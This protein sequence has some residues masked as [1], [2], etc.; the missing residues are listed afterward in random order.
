[1]H[2]ISKKDIG[3]IDLFFIIL[4]VLSYAF[5]CFLYFTSNKTSAMP[6][7]EEIL[8]IVQMNLL[9]LFINLL[10]C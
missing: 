5:S 8:Y 1:M 7:S 2:K 6:T 4:I 3:R 9:Y 10:I